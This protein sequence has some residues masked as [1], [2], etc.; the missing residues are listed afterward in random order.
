MAI[1]DFIKTHTGREIITAGAGQNTRQVF[2]HFIYEGELGIMF[3]DSNTGK[4]ILAND[5]AFFVSGG[6]HDWDGIE[7]TNIPTLYIDM[8]MSDKQYSSRY[9]NAAEYIPDSFY[10]STV[11]VANIDEDAILPAIRTSIIKMQGLDNPPKF[12]IIDNITNGFGSIQNA[13]KMRKMI[14]EFKTLKDRF[15]LTILL[16]AHCPKRRQWKPITQDDLGGSKM[17]INFVDSAFAIAPSQCGEK[18]KYIKQIKTREGRKMDEVMSVSIES[19]P[20]LRFNY[21]GYDAEEDHLTKNALHF[22][23]TEL[24]PEMEIKLV[25]MLESE[26]YSYSEIADTIGIS[27]EAV[28]DY[29]VVNML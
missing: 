23:L 15:G 18:Y 3:G 26:Q 13:T 6:G 21:I 27:K 1:K 14:S 11:S 2:G 19:E 24:T 22:N 12:V 9:A 28:I 8:E 16:I 29:S 25:E 5:I 10:R 17:I 20:F 7:R 4:S